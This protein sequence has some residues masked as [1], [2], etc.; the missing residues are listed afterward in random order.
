MPEHRG[1]VVVAF[2]DARMKKIG[3]EEASCPAGFF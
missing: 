1:H 3:S 2:A